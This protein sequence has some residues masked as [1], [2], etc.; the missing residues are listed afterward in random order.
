MT[1][2]APA[3]AR[4][5]IQVPHFV[6]G[7]LVWGEDNEY[8][9]RDFGVPFVTP[10]I[11]YNELFVPRTEPGPAFDVPISEI[12]D[13]LVETAGQLSLEKNPYLQESL[14]MTLQ[15]SALPRRIIENTFRRPGQFLT[16]KSPRIPART[17]LRKHRRTRRMGREHRSQRQRQQD[18]RL[19]AATRP[20]ARR[21]LAERRH[22]VDRRRGTAQGRQR[23]QDAVGRPVHHRRRAPD[24]GRHR[25]RPPR[26]EVDLRGLL[27]WRRRVGRR[28]AL[29]LA[30]LRQAC[31]VGWRSRDRERGEV[32]G[33]GIRSDLV[34]P[35]GLDGDRGSRGIRV[36]RDATG[37]R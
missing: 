14:E 12:I 36:G 13:F 20:H 32:R 2:T 26:P 21:E 8:L 24:D 10:K 25:T 17:H 37:G 31:G 7:K 3:P 27:A 11:E 5:K 30:V 33:A 35:E 15:V 18:P 4:T 34:R 9:S 19:P 28:R 22:D 23:V 1:A 16:K 29:P 6:R